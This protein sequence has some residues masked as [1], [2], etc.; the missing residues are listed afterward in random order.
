MIKLIV[1]YICT[2]EVQAHTREIKWYK[3][4]IKTVSEI[5]L[6]QVPISFQAVH[7][8]SSPY[9]KRKHWIKSEENEK[10]VF[11]GSAV[12]LGMEDTGLPMQSKKNGLTETSPSDF[13]DQSIESGFSNRWVVY[14]TF[15]TNITFWHWQRTWDLLNFTMTA[16]KLINKNNKLD[17][18]SEYLCG[19]ISGKI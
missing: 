19:C 16:V 10:K 8:H 6:I 5:I 9:K 15:V 12:A 4:I 3:C 13:A 1:E 2:L 11:T 18:S 17:Q 7:L 14:Q